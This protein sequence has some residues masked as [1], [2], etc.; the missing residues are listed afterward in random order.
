MI[1]LIQ[2]IQF[3]CLL[4]SS[5]TMRRCDLGAWNLD[6]RVQHLPW[7]FW[8]CSGILHLYKYTNELVYLQR[9]CKLAEIVID[10]RPHEFCTPDRPLSMFEG[11]AGV[12]FFLLNLR[13][14]E[15]STCNFPG[16]QVNSFDKI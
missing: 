10:D 6:Q 12:I 8:Q 2:G 15:K 3:G 9:A 4:G 1:H 13:E 14:P 7:Y 11:T 5:K 16:Y